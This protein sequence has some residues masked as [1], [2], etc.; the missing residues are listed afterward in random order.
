MKVTE[1][2]IIECQNTDDCNQVKA[3]LET[4]FPNGNLEG[5]TFTEDRDTMKTTLTRTYLDW[6]IPAT[7]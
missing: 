3:F 2:Y 1:T 7:A 5:Y 4:R 6:E